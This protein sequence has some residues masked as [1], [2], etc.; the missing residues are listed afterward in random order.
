MKLLEIAK[1]NVL[2]QHKAG[3]TAVSLSAESKVST[4]IGS[5]KQ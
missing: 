5:V 4:Y 3:V 1:A 2:A